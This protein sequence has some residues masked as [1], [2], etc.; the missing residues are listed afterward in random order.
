M[1]LVLS[2]KWKPSVH[3]GS[4]LRRTGVC[5]AIFYI[6]VIVCYWS[7]IACSHM[8]KMKHQKE[9]CHLLTI[10]AALEAT[11]SKKK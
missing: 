9:F 4:S 5:F 6:Q 2:A 10:E 7:V 8:H 1:M 3:N 11:E